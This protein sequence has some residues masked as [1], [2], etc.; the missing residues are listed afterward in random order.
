MALYTAPN[1]LEQCRVGITVGR[2]VGKA[3]VRNRVR[4]R[5]REA[6]RLRWGDLDGGRDLVFVAR[7]ASATAEWGPLRDATETL[8]ARAGLLRQSARAAAP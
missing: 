2:R 1:G 6:V 5:I 3:V 7:P 8:L 4:R